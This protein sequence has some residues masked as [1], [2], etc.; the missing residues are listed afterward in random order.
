MQGYNNNNNNNN[1]D[2]NN[3]NNINNNEKIIHLIC[4]ALHILTNLKVLQEKQQ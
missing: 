1:D 2:D 4:N 3:N